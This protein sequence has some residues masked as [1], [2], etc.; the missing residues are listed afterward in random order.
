M[1]QQILALVYDAND[2]YTNTSQ[3]SRI[4]KAPLF[5]ESLGV[6]FS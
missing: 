5:S 3:E 2:L 4:L 6:F 1:V